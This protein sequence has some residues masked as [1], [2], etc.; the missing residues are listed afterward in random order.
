MM[1]RQLLGIPA[2]D[3]LIIGTNFSAKMIPQKRLKVVQLN[4]IPKCKWTILF[5]FQNIF[6]DENLLDRVFSSAVDLP[7][8]SAS[9]KNMSDL[10]GMEDEKP[11]KGQRKNEQKP[12]LPSQ[13]FDLDQS[14]YSNQ[15]SRFFGL[16][17]FI[18]S[19]LIFN[20]FSGG[21]FQDLSSFPMP[22]PAKPSSVDQQLAR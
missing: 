11:V 18:F 12:F 6:L 20:Y 16:I 8:S 15:S 19:L 1:L 13:L 17:F 3:F 21:L 2:L 7:A 5:N 9:T 4:V 22:S 10:I 14:L